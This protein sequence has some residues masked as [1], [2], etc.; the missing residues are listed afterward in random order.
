MTFHFSQ[1][2][3]DRL[4]TCDVHLQEL[5]ATALKLT[6]MDF[7]ILC[8]HRSIEEQQALFNADPPTTHID[9]ITKLSNHNHTPSRA[10]DCAPWPI[11]WS[12]MERFRFLG[13]LIIGVAGCRGLRIRWGGDWSMDGDFKDQTFN[14]LPHFELLQD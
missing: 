4:H 11:D 5:M 14:D 7:T 13:G 3:L 9:G 6:P 8:G 1:R 10:V 12:D 2:S